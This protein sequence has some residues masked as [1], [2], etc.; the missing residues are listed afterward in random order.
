MRHRKVMGI[1]S[2]IVVILMAILFCNNTHDFLVGDF[3]LRKMG[4]KVW[5]EGTSGLHYT[6]V[7]AAFLIMLGIIGIIN[8]HKDVHKNFGKF[9]LLFFILAGFTFQPL[10]DSVY[11]F[12]K[13]QMNGL[14]SIEYIRKDSSFSF[15]SDDSNQSILFDSQIKLKNYS[16]ETK[17]FYVRLIP[18]KRYIGF[19]VLQKE[20]TI[21]DNLNK[22]VEYVVGPHSEA[23]LKSQFST[24][25]GSGFSNCSGSMEFDIVIFNQH[26][27]KKFVDRY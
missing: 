27:E 1:A 2:F 12:V 22:P 24:K 16:D 10:S 4:F 14:S 5:S 21:C 15:K 17:R 26:E 18:D 3:I 9:A 6:G 25:Q 11:G 20:I 23:S 8:F 7:A 13:S 19:P